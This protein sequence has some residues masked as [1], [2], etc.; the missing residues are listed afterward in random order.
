MIPVAPFSTPRPNHPP[1]LHP[2]RKPTEAIYLLHK[3]R[4]D[5]LGFVRAV[6]FMAVYLIC[7]PLFIGTCLPTLRKIYNAQRNSARQ[8]QRKA[9]GIEMELGEL[10]MT[11]IPALQKQL[12][13][14][15]KRK[16]FLE[17]RK[18]MGK[19]NSRSLRML[20]RKMENLE[21]EIKSLQGKAAEKEAI[22]GRA[23][24]KNLLISIGTQLKILP[25]KGLS[26]VAQ[27][28]EQKV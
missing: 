14:C 25:K 22:L 2:A 23:L 26:Q 18:E 28:K 24:P 20:S 21:R 27:P 8:F 10:T 19:N 17:K 16:I 4:P 12:M 13:F 7:T 5:K 3:I 15:G 11:D 9:G 6:L 1:D